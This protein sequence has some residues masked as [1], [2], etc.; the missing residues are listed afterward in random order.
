MNPQ[1]SLSQVC[2][3]YKALLILLYL[4]VSICMLKGMYNVRIATRIYLLQAFSFLGFVP[5]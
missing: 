3:D 1:G 4:I 5:T 2:L